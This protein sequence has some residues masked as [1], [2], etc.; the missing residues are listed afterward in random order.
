VHAAGVLDDGLLRDQSPERLRGVAAPKIDGARNLHELVTEPL[1]FFVLF[2]SAAALVGPAGQGT[3]AAANA[4][5]DAFTHHRTSLGLPATSIAWGP[6]EGTGMAA[7]L[8]RLDRERLARQG[9]RPISRQDALDAF[10]QVLGSGAV[11]VG[12]FAGA[13][14]Q[15][16]EHG[17][18]A[19]LGEYVAPDGA[20]ERT[21]SE[22]W[23]DELGIRPVGTTDHFLDLGGDSIM[24]LRM[25]ERARRAGVPLDEAD[26]FD[27]PTIAALAPVLDARRGTAGAGVAA[28]ANPGDEDIRRLL[29]RIR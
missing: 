28:A 5:L 17:R 12:V 8:S 14:D 19:R 6:W 15:A 16:G 13:Q 1:D 20:T 21:L 9:V 7:G 27:H 4:F 2:S 3:Y 29:G 11:H 25:A 24:S 10:D 22:I 23:A 26:V 18:P